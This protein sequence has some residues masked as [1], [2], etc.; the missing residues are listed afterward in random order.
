MRVEW[1]AVLV[2]VRKSFVSR[3]VQVHPVGLK[4]PPVPSLEPY[5]VFARQERPKE[6]AKY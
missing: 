5:D 6:D 1:P 4:I 2:R 3:Y